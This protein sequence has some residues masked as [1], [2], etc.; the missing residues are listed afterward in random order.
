MQIDEGTTTIALARTSARGRLDASGELVLGPERAR[1]RARAHLRLGVAV[2][3]AGRVGRRARMLLRGA[4]RPRP[5]A[6]V[7]G[8]TA[9]CGDS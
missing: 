1:A 7:R 5:V 2:R 4:G 8:R 9:P 3:G 6:I